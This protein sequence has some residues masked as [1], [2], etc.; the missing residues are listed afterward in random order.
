M[1]FFFKYPCLQ[2]MKPRGKQTFDKIKRV[3]SMHSPRLVKWGNIIPERKWACN[4]WGSA[5]F[6][7]SLITGMSHTDFYWIFFSLTYFQKQIMSPIFSG[8]CFK[9]TVNIQFQPKTVKK[10]FWKKLQ[11]SRNTWNLV[12][13]I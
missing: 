3:G 6:F 13:E 2:E 10:I 9:P 1:W 12:N 7:S 5:H 8:T 11:T 4:N